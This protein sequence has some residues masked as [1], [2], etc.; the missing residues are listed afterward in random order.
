MAMEF[1]LVAPDGK[2]KLRLPV[3]PPEFKIETGQNISIV[4]VNDFGEYS[5]KGIKTL[6]RIT[7]SS[8][9]PA[10][11]YS[12]CQYKKIPKPYECTEMIKKWRD[13]EKPCRLII[14]KTKIN[15]QFFIESFIYG[16]RAGSRDVDFELTLVEH[17]QITIPKKK[18]STKKK[19]TKPRPS[20]SK[21]K[22]KTY[23]VK[24]GDSLWDIAR[25]YYKDPYKWKDIAKKNG[26]K[27]PR[28]LQI[29]TVLVLP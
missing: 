19:T 18:K 8:F 26:I 22:P 1:W 27:D 10:K 28:K 21:S 9:F 6:D 14:T 11:Y 29:G 25:E 24:K 5:K 13:N 20:K 23:K 16:E 17:R 2:K 4:E 12:F 15:K 7:I 3:P